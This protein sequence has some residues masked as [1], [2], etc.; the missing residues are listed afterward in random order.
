MLWAEAMSG[1]NASKDD[2]LDLIEEICHLRIT[3]DM[4]APPLPK[5]RDNFHQLLFPDAWASEWPGNP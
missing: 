4:P 2:L 5:T 1:I 3:C